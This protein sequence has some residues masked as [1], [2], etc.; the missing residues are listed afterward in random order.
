M[1]YPM[2]QYRVNFLGNLGI[3]RVGVLYIIQSPSGIIPET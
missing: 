3:P 1:I 2:S